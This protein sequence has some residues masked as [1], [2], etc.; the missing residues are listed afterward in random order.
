AIPL[1][2]SETKLHKN[3]LGK[4][5]GPLNGYAQEVLLQGDQ[6]QQGVSLYDVRDVRGPKLLG[7]IVGAYHRAWKLRREEL[8]LLQVLASQASAVLENMQLM[9]DVVEARNEA[10][11]LLRQVLDD[12]RLKE[13]ILE[14]VPS[15]LITVDLS[16]RITTFN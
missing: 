8:A 3:G 2:V 11:K 7:I 16:G 15:G 1:L 12:Q 10:R 9:T 4:L 6:K 14:S 13:L 5:S